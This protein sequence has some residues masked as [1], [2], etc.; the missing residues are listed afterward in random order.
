MF[1]KTLF[2]YT[3]IRSGINIINIMSRYNVYI[4]GFFSII[5]FDPYDI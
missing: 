3:G 5:T 1:Y 2:T 4:S